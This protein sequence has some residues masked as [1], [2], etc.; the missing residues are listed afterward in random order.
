MRFLLLTI[1]VFL[2]QYVN[3]RAVDIEKAKS[4]AEYYFGNKHTISI[5]EINNDYVVLSK[6]NNQ[7]FVVVAS[8][9]EG[10]TKVIGYSEYGNWDIHTLPPYLVNW[11]NCLSFS[12]KQQDLCNWKEITRSVFTTE[13]ISISPLLNTKWHQKYPYN[14]FA[15]IVEDGNIQSI[16]GCVAIAASQVVNYWSLDNPESTFY[17]TPVYNYGSAPVT[18][19]VPAGTKYRWNLIKNEYTGKESEDEEN[20]VANLVYIVGTSAWLQ[21]SATGTGGHINDVIRPFSSQFRLDGRYYVKSSFSQEEWESLLYENLVKQQPLL[22]GG[23]SGYGGHAVV[24][25]GYD[26]ELNLFHFNFGWGGDG[27]GYYTVDDLTGMNGYNYSQSCVCDIFPLE[28]NISI[29]QETPNVI[30]NNTKKQFS[31]KIRNSSTLNVQE[32]H[33]FIKEISDDDIVINNEDSAVFSYVNEILNN[34]QL[35]NINVSITPNVKAGDYYL[36]LTDEKLRILKQEKISI[37]GS[38][39]IKEFNCEDQAHMTIRKESGN[40]LCIETNYPTK[41][42]IFSINGRTIFSN[43]VD[44]KISLTLPHGLYVINGEKWFQ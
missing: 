38:T 42:E 40:V 44:G 10:I 31:L 15:P 20:A 9:S 22:Y 16:A 3:S 23:D 34:G 18:Y 26:A 29:V 30:Q 1:T 2:C 43:N 5:A 32:L 7:G 4:I 41:V 17:N 36:V 39:E 6:G 19:S 24:I 37:V 35:Y 33:Y 27:D 14:K 13:R 21:Y 25:D 12:N 8:S 28:R 11:F